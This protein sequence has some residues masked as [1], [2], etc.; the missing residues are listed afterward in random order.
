[1][2]G[3]YIHIP[4]CERKCIYCDFYSIEQTS[5]FDGFVQAL[6][7]EICMMG[8]L[9][10]EQRRFATIFFGG[11][12]PSLLSPRQLERIL[13]ALHREFLISPDAEVT[14]ETNPGTVN[15]EK[16]KAY[17]CIGVNRLS[18]GIQSF[19]R[20]DLNFLTRIH[21]G[22]DAILCYELARAAGFDNINVDLIFSMPG[23]TKFRWEYNL[24][25]AIALEP[26]HISA[27]SLMYEEGTP[28][29]RML[30]RREVTPLAE[31]ED[32]ALYDITIEMLE[33]EGYRQYEISNY[34]RPG[35]ECLH[36][37]IYWEHN[38][39]V[40]F[41]PSAHSF[42][43]RK[44]F[45]NVRSV[46]SYLRKVS[47]DE[48]PVAGEEVLTDTQFIEEAIFLGIRSQGIDLEQL[49]E[50]FNYDLMLKKERE[51]LL[52]RSQDLIAIEGQILRVTKKGKAFA[53][54][55]ATELM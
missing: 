17:R 48:L 45:W 15:A 44:R 32:A 8:E 9:L 19:H 1:M 38:E 55:I 30:R 39:Y 42:Y 50:M 34:A 22:E 3:I 53:D 29:H 51:I 23:Q 5:G 54:M 46:E 13:N 28:L 16:L 37:R 2:R 4:F 11:G 14:V 25:R 40:G 49:R 18:I 20:D 12:T 21:T 26:D 52:L 41:G 6:E 24:K 43:R 31:E 27:Y 10:N 7:R 33:S 35:K 36:N 47:L